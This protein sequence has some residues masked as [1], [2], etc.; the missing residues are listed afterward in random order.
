MSDCSKTIS[1]AKVNAEA[2]SDSGGDWR[3]F[4]SIQ[5]VG[6]ASYFGTAAVRDGSLLTA[7]TGNSTAP[8]WFDVWS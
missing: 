2:H 5:A 7:V 6:Q 3:P 1:D 8:T 4:A